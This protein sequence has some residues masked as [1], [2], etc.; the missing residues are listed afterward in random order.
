MIVP[1]E[2][3]CVERGEK[4]RIIPIPQKMESILEAVMD[5][6]LMLPIRLPRVAKYNER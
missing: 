2:L 4:A 1:M 5:M 6:E 3:H